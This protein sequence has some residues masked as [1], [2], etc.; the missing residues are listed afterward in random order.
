MNIRVRSKFSHLEYSVLIV[1]NAHKLI[2]AFLFVS[3]HSTWIFCCTRAT[4]VQSLYSHICV[5]SYT[6]IFAS[7]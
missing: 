4:R 6:F 2:I 1:R 7:S 5:A 3:N